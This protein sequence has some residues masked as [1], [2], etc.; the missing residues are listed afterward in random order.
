MRGLMRTT[1]IALVLAFVLVAPGCKRT[2]E[3]EKTTYTQTHDRL[4]A[5][6]TKNPAMKADITAKLAEFDRDRK[7]ADAKQGDDAIAALTALNSR[8]ANYERSL[9]PPPAA[10]TPDAGKKLGS[11]LGNPDAPPAGGKLGGPATQPATKLGTPDA[12]PAGGKLG[13]PA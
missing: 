2:A 7:A 10:A 6:A 11:K 12:P 8:M 4:E 1:W 13:G 5:L 3:G 9:A